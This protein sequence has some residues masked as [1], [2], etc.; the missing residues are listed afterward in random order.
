M[1]DLRVQMSLDSSQF[2]SGIEQ[3]SSKVGSLKGKMSEIGQGLKD[4]GTKMTA[5]GVAMVASVGGIVAKGA[6]W[7]AS[8]EST[9][10]LYNNLDKTVQK[11]ISTNAKSANH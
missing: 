4:V 6:E 5:A 3:A 1:E 7:S 8:V 2:N 10:F 9:Q 11:S